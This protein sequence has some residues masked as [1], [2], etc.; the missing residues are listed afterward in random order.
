MRLKVG[1]QISPVA[2]AP[3]K[4]PM[5]LIFRDFGNGI[6]R[7]RELRNVRAVFVKERID[8]ELA[9][10]PRGVVKHSEFAWLRPHIYRLRIFIEQREEVPPL[11]ILRQI[12]SS[13]GQSNEFWVCLWLAV[14]PRLFCRRAGVGR[15]RHLLV[16]RPSLS[17]R[18]RFFGC[19]RLGL[20]GKGL[21]FR[22]RFRNFRLLFCGLCFGLRRGDLELRLVLLHAGG[23]CFLERFS[24]LRL[25]LCGKIPEPADILDAAKFRLDVFY[26][27]CSD[28]SE[29]PPVPRLMATD[30]HQGSKTK[31]PLLD[32]FLANLA[33]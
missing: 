20:R 14:G 13:V 2:D 15:R 29:L 11:G 6:A 27:S 32:R 10:M 18:L 17:L 31:L 12:D 26:L 9:S 7:L 21:C 30:V 22:L 19:L 23:D 33:R 1:G 3:R 16:L 24:K 28:V 8:R 5:S 4:G 25:L